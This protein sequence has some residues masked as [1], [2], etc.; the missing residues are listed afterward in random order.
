M[1]A[2]PV[3]SVRDLAVEIDT[4]DGGFRPVDG[5]SLKLSPGE[6]LG[7]VGESGSGKS[8]T[9]MSL[10]RLLPPRA[11]VVSG[12]AHFDGRDLLKLS[13][14]ELRNVR[15]KEIGVV[16]QDP[17]TSL[18]PVL[19]I[20]RQI[21]EAIK[22]HSPGWGW[23]RPEARATELLEM[24]EISNPRARARQYP[25]EF[26]GGMR[27]R[28]MVAMS[29][30]NQPKMI[31]ADEP[32]TALDVTVQAHILDL[33][34]RLQQRTNAGMI[35]ITHDLGVVAELADRVAV[36]YAGKIVEMGDVR[37]IFRQP[38][39]PYTAGLL[40]SRPRILGHPGRLEPIPG[41]PP[42][43][44]RRPSGCLFH[45]RCVIGRARPRCRDEAPELIEESDGHLSA[46]H[47]QAELTAKPE[48]LA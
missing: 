30:A 44:S 42:D 39:H 32:T 35:L 8:L 22:L 33:L 3:L 27:Q 47:Y 20:G 14:A 43:L 15:G 31:I 13:P 4:D 26:S 2:D 34:R 41:Q 17:M 29:I 37:S 11:R 45:T 23:R 5:I 40:R 25:H 38:R 10:L 6:V 46:C 19:S 1:N 28:V 48:A 21:A 12:S 36:M 24:V 7:L 16:F 9:M 18:N